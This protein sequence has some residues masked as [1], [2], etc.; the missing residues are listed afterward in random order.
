MRKR[1]RNLFGGA[2]GQ[3]CPLCVVCS[4]SCAVVHLMCVDLLTSATQEEHGQSS[5]TN[6]MKREEHEPSGC[7]AAEGS[8]RGAA[9]F[10]H[11]IY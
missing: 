7:A 5:P 6:A 8:R 1:G 10:R 3:R 11:V 9:L 2:N 4:S